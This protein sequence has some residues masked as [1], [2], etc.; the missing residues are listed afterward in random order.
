[1]AGTVKPALSAGSGQLE[2]ANEAIWGQR[3]L[4]ERFGQ[5]TGRQL[6]D[7]I[8]KMYEAWLEKVIVCSV[9]HVFFCL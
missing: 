6:Q 2:A 8:F 7:H 4:L 1:M 9:V 5:A 3:S